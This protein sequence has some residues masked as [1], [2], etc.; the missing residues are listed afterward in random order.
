MAIE[1]LLDLSTISVEE[2]IG[3]LRTAEERCAMPA[4]TQDTGHLLLTK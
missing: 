3:G 4:V 1:T 2:L